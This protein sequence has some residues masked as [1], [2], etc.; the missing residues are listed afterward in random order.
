MPSDDSNTERFE[1]SC[2]VPVARETLFRYHERPGALSRLIPPWERVRVVSS[3]QSLESGSKVELEI[4]VGPVPFRWVAMHGE[5]DPPHR[6]EDFQQSGPFAYWRH[7][8]RFLAADPPEQADLTNASSDR[9]TLVDEIDYRLPLGRLGSL[10]GGARV[11]RQLQAMFRY[12]HRTTVDDLTLIERHRLPKL[13]VAVS[14]ANGLV[15]EPLSGLLRLAGHRV[16]RLV[17][18]PSP[19]DRE[20]GPLAIRP[21]QRQLASGQLPFASDPAERASVAVWQEDAECRRLDGTDAVIH[22][23][24]KSI[25]ES[26]WTERVKREIADS[27]VQPTRQLCESLAR[28]ANPPKTLLCASAIGIYGDRGDEVLD[29]TS[30]PGEDFLAKVAVDWERA[31][32]PA[33]EA[34]IRVV[35]L[36]FGV[37]LSPRGGALAKMLPP[38]RLGAGGRFGGGG[39]W[40]SWIGI[41]DVLGA[42]YHCLANPTITGPVNVVAPEAVTNADFTREL[43]RV[44]RRPTLLPAPAIT[45]R[46]ALGEM[47]DALLLSS[48]HVRP[49]KLA[50][51]GYAFRHP[52]LGE[53]LRHL[54]GV[55]D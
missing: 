53:C 25:A 35:H 14:G 52:R 10:L 7:V 33:V 28:L 47:A 15:G 27:R 18:H 24:G 32:Q 54:L 38:T 23:A 41:D 21:E 36:R 16:I 17:R 40:W 51:T 12:R 19:A 22:L 50:A 4:K 55:P 42:I 11:R 9:S 20:A 31:C 39:Q 34:G 45:L 48:A 26:R 30:A 13:A 49:T 29:E 5:C 2:S 6:F 43:G 44:L 46:L 3:D 37:I 1:A 8:H